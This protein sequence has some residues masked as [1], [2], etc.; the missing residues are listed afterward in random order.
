MTQGQASSF[1][2]TYGLTYPM[3]ADSD[4]YAYSL[5]YINGYVPLNY[6]VDQDFVVQWRDEGW[7]TSIRNEIIDLIDFIF[8]PDEDGDGYRDAAL[9]GDDCDDTDP[10][11]HPCALE[12][13]ENG[14]DEDCSGSDRLCEGIQE[15]EPNDLPESSQDVGYVE[16]ASISGNVCLTGND[17]FFYTGDRDYYI[18]HTPARWR[19]AV[20]NVTLGWPGSGNFDI[21]L[22]QA[23]GVTPVAY[24]TTISNPETL[25]V[26]LISD[27]DYVIMIAGWSGDPGDYM[28]DLSFGG[29]PDNDGDGY[30]DEACGGTD[31]DDSDSLTYPDADEICDGIDNN[32]NGIV[33]Q[34][35]WDDDDD[36]WRVCEG[37]CDDDDADVSPGEEESETIGNCADGLDNDCDDLVDTDPECGGDGGDDGCGCAVFGSHAN[38]N[39]FQLAVIGIIYLLPLGFIRLL[40]RRAWNKPTP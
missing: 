9:G 16:I 6:V 27:T 40:L 31:C 20:L 2:N 15:A 25:L 4:S 39:P 8:I 35:E 13:C 14:I 24:K 26:T 19:D 21:W 18:F 3:L 37:D 7:S 33:P 34:D 32:C 11:I 17:G 23:D 22:Y 30:T 29:C 5:Y 38:P 10:D 36:G 1:K 12:I 28:L